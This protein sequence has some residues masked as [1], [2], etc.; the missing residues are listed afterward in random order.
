[1][2]TKALTLEKERVSS[3]LQSQVRCMLLETLLLPSD[4]TAIASNTIKAHM[5][6]RAL[7]LENECSTRAVLTS[8]L[9]LGVY[10]SSDLKLN[11]TVTLPGKKGVRLS[12]HQEK[13]EHVSKCDLYDFFFGRVMEANSF[14]CGAWVF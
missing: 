10:P 7:P 1:M 8:Q 6:R 14:K 5:L 2:V 11:G 4:M 3:V 13:K 9:Q 12:L